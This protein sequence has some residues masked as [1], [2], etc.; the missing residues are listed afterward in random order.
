MFND[1]YDSFCLS[2]IANSLG[3]GAVFVATDTYCGCHEYLQLDET[4]GGQ[5]QARS[6]TSKAS[7]PRN[8]QLGDI[9]GFGFIRFWY[10]VDQIS[11]RSEPSP[12]NPPDHHQN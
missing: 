4:R 9:T 11:G 12:E 6:A 8:A 5:S 2:V 3:H 7:P 1:G 10:E